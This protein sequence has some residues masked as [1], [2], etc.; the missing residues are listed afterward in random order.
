MTDKKLISIN[1]YGPPAIGK[2]GVRAG[3]FFLLKVLHQNVAEHHEYAQYAS[4]AGLTWQLSEEQLFVFNYQHHQQ[5]LSVKNGYDFAV[6]DSPLHLS[7]FY[8]NK[9]FGNELEALID[10]A[11]AAVHNLNFFLVA[12][13]EASRDVGFYEAG[14]RHSLDESKRLGPEL[15]KYLDDK[16]IPYE[17]LPV[18]FHTPWLIVERLSAVVR[19]RGQALDLAPL[20]Q[21]PHQG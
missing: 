21:I 11:Y 12:S 1:L 2:S 10:K 16:G 13:D 8:G 4:N 20:I 6:T 17:V 5:L 9:S 7:G 15:Q 3:V 19:A 18:S 14:R